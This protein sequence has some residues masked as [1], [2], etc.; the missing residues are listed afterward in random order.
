MI[1]HTM[2]QAIA[3]G[4]RLIMMHQEEILFE[5]AGEARQRARVGNIVDLFSKQRIFDDELL[6]GRNAGPRT[7]GAAGSGQP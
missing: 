6:F 7:R 5:F 1:T 2:D 3:L 4:N